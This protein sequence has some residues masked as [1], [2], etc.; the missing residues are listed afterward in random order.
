M[1]YSNA[2][3]DKHFLL[4]MV[5]AF[6]HIRPQTGVVSKLIALNPSLIFTILVSRH[7]VHQVENELSLACLPVGDLARIRVVGLGSPNLVK[8]SLL[9]LGPDLCE[10][11]VKILQ[12]ESITCMARGTTFTGI[13]PPS[14]AILDAF[15]P[16]LGTLIK[17]ITP[18]VYIVHFWSTAACSF[19]S[20]FG[21]LEYGGMAELEARTH[22]ALDDSKKENGVSFDELVLKLSSEQRGDVFP[23]PQGILMY[24]YE[25]TPQST[26]PIRTPV[27]LPVSVL[28]HGL[29]QGSQLADA[30]MLVVTRDF[31]PEN[32]RALEDWYQGRL[33]KKLFFVGPQVPHQ[34][35]PTDPTDPSAKVFAFLDSH[36]P[37][38]VVLISF[39]TV[40]YPYND[41]WRIEAIVKT[42][43]ETKTPFIF[44]RAAVLAAPLSDELTK[45][46]A[47]NEGLSL[48]AG[49]LPQSQALAHPSTAAILS[50]GGANS[51]FESI[52]AN[53]ISIFWPGSFDQPMH[54]AYLSQ[55]LD[56]AFELM[57]VRTG[58]GAA[59]PYRG[60]KVEGT[61]EAV[62]AEF[63][64]VLADLKGEVGDHK[65]RNLQKLHQQF[66]DA[67][68]EGGQCE[69]D[70]RE[71]LSIT[72]EDILS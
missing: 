11:Y 61:S 10:A 21:P 68:R 48:M 55:N 17:K 52:L 43:I 4:A 57:Q 27:S 1:S 30:A 64:Q 70:L 31:Q 29:R 72:P 65:R 16:Q 54:A 71:L 5:P 44:S 20:T 8:P 49:W 13:P 28:L 6:G 58:K 67:M 12:R 14:V 69:G 2:P 39:G 15:A 59:A 41:L 7:N 51:M 3:E 47:D 40:W 26:N 42:L 22:A 62:A 66:V 33:G 60:G 56:C 25:M 32:T 38:S 24:D 37:K 34:P 9:A 19:L 36:P 45:A 35:R 53:T 23:S 18:E 63:K 50:H 46:L